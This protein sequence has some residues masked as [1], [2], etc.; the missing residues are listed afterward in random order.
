M[1][2]EVE[3]IG[4][5]PFINNARDST[6]LF[7]AQVKMEYSILITRSESVHLQ[8]TASQIDRWNASV[9]AA[10]LQ[11][12]CRS[13][14]VR[15]SFLVFFI[16]IY[17]CIGALV[18]SVIEAPHEDNLR[19]EVLKL[20]NEFLTHHDCVVGEFRALFTIVLTNKHE[21]IN[22]WSIPCFRH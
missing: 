3:C 20:R 18:F 22:I 12:C 9:M 19:K 14:S 16:L 4:V 21:L 5:W 17:L 10:S 1:T 15:L 6:S 8:T 7:S 11:S 13:S 2:F